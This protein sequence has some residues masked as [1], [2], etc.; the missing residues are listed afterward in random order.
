MCA[1]QI[2]WWRQLASAGLRQN[3]K[4]AP[5]QPRLHTRSMQVH[6]KIKS[7]HGGR[8]YYRIKVLAVCSCADKTKNGPWISCLCLRSNLSIQLVEALPPYYIQQSEGSVWIRYRSYGAMAL[9]WTRLCRSAVT[10]MRLHQSHQSHRGGYTS[11]KSLF[12]TVGCSFFFF[13]LTWAC[14]LCAEKEEEGRKP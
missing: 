4:C 7:T 2:P 6:E 13:H 1:C 9:S 11:L 10:I 12:T 3:G 5:S 14:G 8:W